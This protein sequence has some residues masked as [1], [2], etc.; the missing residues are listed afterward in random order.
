M[1]DSI[2]TLIWE[3][4]QNKLDNVGKVLDGKQDYLKVSPGQPGGWEA[5]LPEGEPWPTAVI[6]QCMNGT[7][8]IA[9]PEHICV[10]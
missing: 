4:I 6:G 1:R 7:S 2:D 10:M 3:A 5:G 9:W 8:Y